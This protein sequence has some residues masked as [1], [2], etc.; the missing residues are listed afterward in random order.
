VR[1]AK[2]KG[3]TE[4][5]PRD[6]LNGMDV[7]RKVLILAREA[8]ID[9][10]LSDVDVKSLVPQDCLDAGSIDEFFM[11]LQAHDKTYEDLRRVA[12]EKNERLRYMAVLENGKRKF[13]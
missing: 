5:D 6:D 11:K 2:E 12:E 13:H 3:Y 4:P 10:E 9:L 1:E 7:A 8:G